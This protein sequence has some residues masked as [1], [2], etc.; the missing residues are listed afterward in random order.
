MLLLVY[1]PGFLDGAD[2]IFINVRRQAFRAAGQFVFA[3]LRTAQLKEFAMARE[4]NSQQ[5][6]LQFYVSVLLGPKV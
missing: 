1:S 5:V 2:W 6:W 4:L 3:P